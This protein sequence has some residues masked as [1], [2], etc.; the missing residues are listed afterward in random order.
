MEQTHE[1]AMEKDVEDHRLIAAIGY[2]GIL[3]LIP[4]L[5]AKDSPFAQHHGKQGLVILLAWIVLWIGNIVPVIGW[6]AWALGSVALFVLVCL[7]M[8][9][10]LNG[11]RWV[12]PVLGVYAEKI[13]L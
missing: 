5:L 1:P 12:A 13:K 11:K 10:A 3:C 8:V 7:G 6:M 4:L 2:L 9:N